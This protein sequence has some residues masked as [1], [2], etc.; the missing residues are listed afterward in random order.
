MEL[1]GIEGGK[2]LAA[3]VAAG[4]V[5]AACASQR[6]QTQVEL[7]VDLADQALRPVGPAGSPREGQLAWEGE[8]LHFK[9]SAS[10]DNLDLALFRSNGG[11]APLSL[12]WQGGAEPRELHCNALHKKVEV[13]GLKAE[14]PWRMECQWQGDERPSLLLQEGGGRGLPDYREGEYRRT[15]LVLQLRSLHRQARSP[16]PQGVLGYV[17][18]HEGRALA[19]VDLGG[20]R[21]QVVL[22][23]RGE[24]LARRTASDLALALALAWEPIK[25]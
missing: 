10:R 2:R 11:K 22:A 8:Q 23:P 12:R 4:L 6:V 19:A 14:K 25:N 21:P 16:I 18:E 17:I 9:R 1:Q 20:D 13:L 5:L 7:P 24:A 3:V 15:G